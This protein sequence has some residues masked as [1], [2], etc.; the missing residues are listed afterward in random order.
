MRALRERI[1][2]AG[3]VACTWILGHLPFRALRPL[4]SAA[5]SLAYWLDLRGHR[6]ALE[7][8]EAAF[9]GKFSA[10][11]KSAIARRSYVT[12]A[13][14][15]FELCWAP[16]MDEEFFRRHV[17]F[18]GWD[19]DYARKD[20]AKPA[21][22]ACLHYGNFEW[23]ALAGAYSISPGPVIAQSFRNPRLGPVFD[24]LR[25]STGNQVIPQERAMIRMLKYLKGGGK[26][27]MLCDLNL[28]PREGSVLITCFGGLLASVTQTHAALAQ[29]TGAAIVPIE[30]RPGP[31][32]NYRIIHH[33]PIECPPDAD[34]RE[35]VQQCWNALEPGIHENPE[36]WLWAYKHWRYKPWIHSERYPSYANHSKRFDKLV[37]RWNAFGT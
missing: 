2:Y 28:D 36:C 33:T 15:M 5:G 17:Q 23:L 4:A 30:C 18:E 19:K 6:V 29:R 35:I 1:E 27:G 25:S 9:P 32:G 7:N 8:I 20:P 10:S 26:F 16:N 22:Y 24:R 11:R 37:K 31:S 13:R 21:I 3:L 12:F 14:T 34:P